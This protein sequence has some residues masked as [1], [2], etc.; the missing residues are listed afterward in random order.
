MNA[1][2]LRHKAA[3]EAVFCFHVLFVAA[4]VVGVPLQ[5]FLPA[6]AKIQ[7][8]LIL[9][10]ASSQI[11]FL[12]NCPLTML[13]NFFRKKADPS[14]AYSGSCIQHYLRKWGVNTP[15]G[16]TTACLILILG[17]SALPIFVEV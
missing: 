14:T 6:Y 1:S 5:F 4:L 8:A 17:L 15:R 13:E 16:F 11:L 9:L 12:G 2:N 7:M 10:A 3:S